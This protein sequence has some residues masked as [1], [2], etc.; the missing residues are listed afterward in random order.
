MGLQLSELRLEPN[1]ALEYA[2]RAH[3]QDRDTRD[4]NDALVIFLQPVHQRSV[5]PRLVL[6]NRSPVIPSEYASPARTEESLT[7]LSSIGLRSLDF[8]RDDKRMF[9]LM[10]E[11]RVFRLRAGARVRVGKEP[12]LQSEIDELDAGGEIDVFVA[13]DEI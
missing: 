8:A 11:D 5:V 3:Q 2:K 4:Q 1:R 7:I 10:L 12:S 9:L 13:N 6:A